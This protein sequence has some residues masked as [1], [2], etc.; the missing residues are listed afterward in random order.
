MLIEWNHLFSLSNLFSK[1]FLQLEF[2]I[3]NEITPE[4][5]KLKHHHDNVLKRGMLV[6]RG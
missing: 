1:G 4:Q 2:V 3:E 6:K 5:L